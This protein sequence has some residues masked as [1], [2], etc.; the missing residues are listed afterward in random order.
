MNT[1]AESNV[2]SNGS[3]QPEYREIQGKWV[4]LAVFGFGVLATS[5][6]WIYWQ[7]HM[8]PFMPIQEVLIEKFPNSSPRVNGGQER[9]HKDTPSVLHVAMRVAFDPENE[10]A[11]AEAHVD[12]VEE[13]LKPLVEPDK[14]EE[15]H[16]RLFHEQPEKGILKKTY[17]RIWIPREPPESDKGGTKEK[18]TGS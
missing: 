17:K 7:L 11:T 16:V 14:W 2:E 6:L 13:V 1:P 10:E 9:M 4:V 18:S 5:S 8:M 15:L 3:P 12:K